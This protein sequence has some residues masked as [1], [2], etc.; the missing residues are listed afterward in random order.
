MA[1]RFYLDTSIWLDFLERRDEPNF[2][3]GTWAKE[4][5][6]KIIKNKGKILFSDLNILELANIGY[7]EFEIEE[8]LAGFKAAIVHVE[9]TENEIRKA[10]DLSQKR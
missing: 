2:P 3:K 1:E 5:I 9:S 7:S 8:I 6:E 4:M 10:K